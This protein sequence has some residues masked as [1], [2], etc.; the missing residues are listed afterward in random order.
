MIFLLKDCVIFFCVK[1]FRDFLGE[2]VVLFLV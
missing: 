2:E 1:R